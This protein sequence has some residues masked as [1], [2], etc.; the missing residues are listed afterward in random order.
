MILK[1]FKDKSN[2]KFINKQVDFRI[3]EIS[4]T[5]IESVGIILNLS[6]F[7]DFEKF[8]IFF[9]E[10][11]LNPNKIKLTGF[12]EDPKL[13][14]TSVE[15]L[16]S[17]KQIGWRG[18]IRDNEL[19]SFLN[20]P[21]DALISYYKNDNLELNLITALS[22]ANFKVGLSTKDERL[23]DLILDVETKEFDLFKAEFIKYLTIL[24]KL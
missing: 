18:R 21:F 11:K 3:P 4:S 14:E 8:R 12:T 1:G 7:E 9:E 6:E 24:K 15:L 2:Q 16:Y 19:Q 22:K 5:K 17:E 23:H 10:L 13:T 20:T